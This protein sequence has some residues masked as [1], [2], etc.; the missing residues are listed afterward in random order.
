MT[1]AVGEQCRE[2]AAH[3]FLSRLEVLYAG[4]PALYAFCSCSLPLLLLARYR[5][6]RRE[7]FATRPVCPPQLRAVAALAARARGALNP[8]FALDA[9][10]LNKAL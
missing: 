2:D 8:E 10:V 7:N 4:A 6:S 1:V 5:V 3:G 9:G